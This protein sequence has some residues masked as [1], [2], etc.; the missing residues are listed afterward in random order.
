M[1]AALSSGIRRETYT[2]LRAKLSA[3]LRGSDDLSRA[4]NSG[5]WWPYLHQFSGWQVICLSPAQYRGAHTGIHV[6]ECG[7]HCFDRWQWRQCSYRGDGRRRKLL[8]QCCG[9]WQHFDCVRGD[10][11]V[12]GH[13][14]CR[15]STRT[16]RCGRGLGYG[17]G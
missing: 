14:G 9:N 17:Y 1:H 12:D 11:C 6:G 2:A 5:N 13:G 8:C 16:A 15:C 10:G 7:G 3:V 4:R